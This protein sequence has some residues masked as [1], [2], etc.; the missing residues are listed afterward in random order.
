MIVRN[1]AELRA[2]PKADLYELLNVNGATIGCVHNPADVEYFFVHCGGQG[3]Y[4]KLY[5]VKKA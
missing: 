3:V 2:A 1:I 5:E 4:A